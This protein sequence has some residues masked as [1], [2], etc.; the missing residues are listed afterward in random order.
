MGVT[1]SVMG[2]DTTGAPEWADTADTPPNYPPK[3]TSSEKGFLSNSLT[4][5]NLKKPPR[6]GSYPHLVHLFH[7]AFHQKKK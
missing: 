3:C 2:R 7:C 6:I 4:A 1:H 5:I